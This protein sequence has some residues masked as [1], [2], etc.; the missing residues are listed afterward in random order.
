MRRLLADVLDAVGYEQPLPTDLAVRLASLRGHASATIAPLTLAAYR[1]VNYRREHGEED[2]TPLLS[3]IRVTLCKRIESSPAAFAATADHMIA[4]T[5]AVLADLEAGIVRLPRRRNVRRW[6]PRSA[7]TSQP[8][9]SDDKL[10]D[11][12]EDLPADEARIES[13]TR[14]EVSRLR[15]DLL[16]DLFTLEKLAAARAAIPADPKK[17]ALAKLILQALKDPRGPKLVIFASSRET[18]HDL[19]AWLENL[20][21]TDERYRRLRGRLINLGCRPAPPPTAVARG[22]EGFAPET[23]S[24]RS[25][26]VSLPA[27][28]DDYDVLICTDMF[29]EGVNLQ[30]A[31]MCINYDLTWNPQRLGQR[32]G[33][34]DRLGSPHATVTCWTVLPDAGLDI[35]LGI[36][37]ILV[38]KAAIAAE[39]IGAGELFPNSPCKSYTSLLRT[40]DPPAVQPTVPSEPLRDHGWLAA[41]LGNALRIPAVKDAI[42]ALPHGVGAVHPSTR[43]GAGVVFCFRIHEGT[44]QHKTAFAHV[45]AGARRGGATVL[46]QDACLRQVR[47]DP[48]D[49]ISRVTSGPSPSLTGKILSPPGGYRPMRQ[50]DLEMAWSLLETAR[51]AVAAEHGIPSGVADERIQLIAWML[52]TEAHPPATMNTDPP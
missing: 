10:D 19:G 3:L 21:N 7:Q 43:G 16:A 27:I 49:W 44:G 51:A 2:K 4:T 15:A 52:F 25:T 29:S 40:W 33:R 37:D 14:Y 20:I 35:V 23:A 36:M 34:L 11:A 30:Q 17:E 48:T 18:T 22:L 5:R 50:I 1:R 47:L 46:N 12:L 9:H 6:D 42:T 41:W 45:H 24:T 28:S 26:E 32:V 39:T 8:D 13:V 38:H 31:S